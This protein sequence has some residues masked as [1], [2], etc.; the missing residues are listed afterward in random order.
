MGPARRRSRRSADGPR[1]RRLPRRDDRPVC[2]RGA[3]PVVRQQL[4]VMTNFF[5]DFRQLVLAVLGDMAAE[6]NL[7]PGLDLGRVTVEPPRDP[8]HGDLAANAAMGPART[9]KKDPRAPA[10]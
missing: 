10:S 7:P 8:A 1:R 9:L 3:P 5:G 4:S 6:G 2:S